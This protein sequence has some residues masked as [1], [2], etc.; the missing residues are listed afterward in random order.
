MNTNFKVIGLTR[1]AIKPESRAPEADALTTWPSELLSNCNMTVENYGIQNFIL[2]MLA[3]LQHC[4][5]LTIIVII[6]TQLVSVV[7]T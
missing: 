5:T 2:D 7:Q 1:L 6:S 4:I 3:V